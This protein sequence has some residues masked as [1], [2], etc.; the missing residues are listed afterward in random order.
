MMYLELKKGTEAIYE[1]K[2]LKTRYSRRGSIWTRQAKMRYVEKE[3]RRT[4]QEVKEIVKKELKRKNRP[5]E[6][7]HWV[8]DYL[9]IIKKGRLCEGKN[10][11]KLT[12][13]ENT[14]LLFASWRDDF[15]ERK[16][17]LSALLSRQNIG[18]LCKEE[19]EEIL[20]YSWAPV[21]WWSDK[22]WKAWEV[23]SK[24][25]MPKVRKELKLLIYGDGPLKKRFDRFRNEIRGFGADYITE[26]LMFLF[27]EKCCLWNRVAAD[28]SILI[29]IN[30][31]L[32]Y[33]AWK[34]RMQVDGND[35]VK[36]CETLDMIKD[37]LRENNVQSPNFLDVYHFMFCIYR[38]LEDQAS[39]VLDEIRNHSMNPT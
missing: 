11:G 10:S 19:I 38:K 36:C 29:G 27:P 39:F 16:K 8:K 25:L 4:I 35:Y 33:S 14:A 26:I 17:L 15:E 2:H 23:L 22:P 5:L 37:N 13:E 24:N 21:E 18:Y 1:L 7:K 31:F 9:E 20:Q 12:R 34:Y 32:P 3:V 28:F 6:I 30:Q